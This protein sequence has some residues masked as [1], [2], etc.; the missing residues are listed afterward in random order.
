MNTVGTKNILF[1]NMVYCLILPYEYHSLICFVWLEE[2]QDNNC[3]YTLWLNSKEP[4]LGTDSLCKLH[5][6][7]NY[8]LCEITSL[9]YLCFPKK[10]W[11]CLHMLPKCLKHKASYFQKINY[12]NTFSKFKH[13]QINDMFFYLGVFLF[14]TNIKIANILVFLDFLKSSHSWSSN[15]WFPHHI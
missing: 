2:N 7:S 13:N 9:L 12:C 1:W 8:V 10:W 14:G 4:K 11:L 6:R 3:I 15:S 5:I